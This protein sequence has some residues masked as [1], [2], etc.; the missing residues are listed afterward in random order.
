MIDRGGLTT[1]V[2]QKV[3]RSVDNAL[4]VVGGA[5]ALVAFA[6]PSRVGTTRPRCPVVGVGRPFG[7]LS[8]IGTWASPNSAQCTRA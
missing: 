5:S 3:G 2:H 8:P 6:L 7:F 1:E 4:D